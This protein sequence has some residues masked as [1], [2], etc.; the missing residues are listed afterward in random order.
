[1]KTVQT[2]APGKLYIA[3]EY[4]VVEPGQAAVITA[5][6][7]FVSAR[8][9]PSSTDF[10]SIHSVGFTQKPVKWQRLNNQVELENASD[11][12]KYVVSAIQTTEAYLVENGLSLVP[13]DLEIES[14]LDDKDGKKLGLGSSGAVTV[15]TVEALLEF[16]DVRLS[17]LLI[18]KLSVLAQMNLGINS[19]FGDIAA[20]T[21]TG[22]IEY[23]S[24]NRDYVRKF[25]L[26]HSLTETIETYWPKLMIR[27]MRVHNKVN[28]L[29]GWT[30]SPASSHNLVGAVQ[31]RKEQTNKEYAHFLE[32]SFASVTLLVIGLEEGNPTKIKD[33]LNR[34]RKALLEMGKNTNVVIETPLLRNLC[35]IVWKHGGAAKTSGAG[36]GDSGI[37]F[38]FAKKHIKPVS[39]EWKKNGITPLS[40]RVYKENNKK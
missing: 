15:A 30:G 31:E 38:L 10:G 23:A 8:I 28:F 16:Y 1:M 20:S 29:T 32:E 4:A 7:R 36:G 12:L 3:G 40:L 19:S 27:K 22:W 2:K 26:E 18:Y 33:A 35:E 6:N 13:F 9:S 5:V 11:S 21:Y 25:L 14:E 39:E 34:N 24:F 17:K 37:A